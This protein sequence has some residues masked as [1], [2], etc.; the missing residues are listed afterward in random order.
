MLDRVISPNMLIEVAKQ[1]TLRFHYDQRM[2]E[3]LAGMASYARQKGVKVE[4]VVNPYFPAFIPRIGNLDTLIADVELA[5]GLTV[6][7]FADAVQTTEA[8]GDY[9]HVNKQGARIY[10]DKLIEVGVLEASKSQRFE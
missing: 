5:T 1:P 3:K 10:M 4:L 2:L 6:R 9:Q 8:F 7:N